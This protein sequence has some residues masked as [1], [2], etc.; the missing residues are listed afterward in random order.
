MQRYNI[1]LYY[2][3][4][5]PANNT[6]WGYIPHHMDAR[7]FLQNIKH[8][9]E[10]HAMF[11]DPYML[12]FERM[13]EFDKVRAQRFASLYYPHILRTRLYQASTLGLVEDEAVQFVLAEI[14]DDEYGQGDITRSHMQL[15]RNFMHAVG[16][17]ILP[18][19]EYQIIPELAD[20]INAMQALTRNGDWL[21]AVAAVGIASEWPIPRYYSCLLA[22]LK[23]IPAI[24]IHNLE[25]FSGHISLD[26]EHSRMIE[27][28][29]LPHLSSST[30]Q[31]RFS[32]G[33]EINMRLRRK[34][35]EGLYREVFASDDAD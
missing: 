5:P 3:I 4:N 10:N 30:N 8:E 34:L 19:D 31:Q 33:I 21:S 24:G 23:K 16:C 1:T 13:E 9:L 15:Y 25:L 20:Y 32:T 6:D 17:E 11:T 35:H 26:V 22:G 2:L 18:A 12:E 27:E 28:A 14:I 7:E 29:V